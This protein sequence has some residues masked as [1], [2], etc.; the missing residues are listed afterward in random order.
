MRV[1]EI[2]LNGVFYDDNIGK[3]FRR[4]GISRCFCGSGTHVPAVED[5]SERMVTWC[6]HRYY[7][8]DFIQEISFMHV[9]SQEEQAQAI[10]AACS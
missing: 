4:I 8:V 5:L 6:F 7:L 9:Q 1:D 2:P 3:F 10:M